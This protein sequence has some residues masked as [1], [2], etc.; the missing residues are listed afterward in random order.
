MAGEQP[1][2][3]QLQIWRL[4]DLALLHTITLPDG[5]AGDESMMTA[6]PRVLADGRTVLV[7]T[8]RCGLY[9]MEGLEGERRRRAW[10]RRSLARRRPTA[11]SRWWRGTTIW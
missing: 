7:S 3:R 2:S 5:P 1:A 6:E 8:F 4:S 10:S 11:R 9:L